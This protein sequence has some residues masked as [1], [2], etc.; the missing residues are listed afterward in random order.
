VRAG[1]GKQVRR[2][3][4]A[5]DMRRGRLGGSLTLR[6][7]ARKFPQPAKYARRLKRVARHPDVRQEQRGVFAVMPYRPRLS[8]KGRDMAE[9]TVLLRNEWKCKE[10]EGEEGRCSVRVAEEVPTPPCLKEAFYAK[11]F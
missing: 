8:S 6:R 7:S 2:E 11:M 5:R 9:V 4:V 1:G 3:K 10:S